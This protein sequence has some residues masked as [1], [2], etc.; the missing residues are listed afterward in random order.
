M[1]DMQ[2][3]NSLIYLD[4]IVVFTTTFNEH[5]E[6]LEAVFRRLQTNNLKLKA[7][8]CEFLRREVIY[9]GHVV[10]GEGIRTD[11]E[12]SFEC[13]LASPATTGYA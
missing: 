11:T 12:K 6:I 1:G 5:I 4:D 7:F 3:R 13:F 10:S 8:K 9:L 2:L